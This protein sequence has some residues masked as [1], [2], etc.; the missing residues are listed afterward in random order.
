M[1]RE[2]RLEGPA[3][4]GL[5]VGAALLR[6]ALDLTIEGARRALRLRLQGRSTARGRLPDLISRA[7]DFTVQI[8]EGSTILQFE[9]PT[10]RQ[11]D[12]TAF[13]QADLFPEVSPDLT[14]LDYLAEAFGDAIHRPAEVALDGPMIEHLLQYERVF[15]HGVERIEFRTSPELGGMRLTVREADLQSL[16]GLQDRI[17]APQAVRIAG[18][19]DQIRHSDGTF[20]IDL[21]SGERV[22]GI[23]GPQDRDRLQHLWGKSA[24][25]VGM[26]HFGSSGR[27]VRI[28]AESVHAATDKDLQLWAFPPQPRQTDSSLPSLRVPQGPRSGVNAI[29]GQ[30]PGD[31]DD[32][33]I[34]ELL[35]QM[36]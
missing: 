2:L 3:L 32:D 11:A 14:G 18:T 6:D 5:V 36:S 12:E 15:A 7:T 10:L 22:K 24:L 21:P 34:M 9:A 35:E 4:Q 16:H 28:E 1:K 19:L 8:R 27:V 20:M 17:P 23:G 25:V 30:W 26:A 13:A 29:L 31:E 33:R